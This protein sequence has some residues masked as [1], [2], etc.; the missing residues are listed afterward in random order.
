MICAI[1]ERRPRS[2]RLITDQ[3]AARPIGK[4]EFEDQLRHHENVVVIKKKLEEMGYKMAST[5]NKTTHNEFDFVVYVEPSPTTSPREAYEQKRKGHPAKKKAVSM[6]GAS[7][8][9]RRLPLPSGR[10]KR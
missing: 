1:Y 6:L 2:T 10:K 7:G 5:P 3:R 4:I 8:P 9:S